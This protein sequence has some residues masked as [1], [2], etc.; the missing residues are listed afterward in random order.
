MAIKQLTVY[1]VLFGDCIDIE[2]DNGEKL[3]VDCGSDN[4]SDSKKDE[5]KDMIADSRP[6]TSEG[7]V[8]LDVVVTHFHSDHYNI[9]SRFSKESIRELYMPDFFS[10]DE[11]KL[12]LYLLLL[13]SIK[14]PNN[15]YSKALAML[16][17]I[18]NLVDFYKDKSK[19][20]LQRRCKINFV[21]KDSIFK[22]FEVLWPDPE[23]EKMKNTIDEVI[24]DIENKINDHQFLLNINIISQ[25][26]DYAER[27]EMLIN[28]IRNVDIQQDGYADSALILNISNEIEFIIDS[29]RR[30]REQIESYLPPNDSIDNLLLFDDTTKK[31]IS[32]IQNLAS[33]VFHNKGDNQRCLFL[34]DITK[35]NYEDYISNRIIS[36][37]YLYIKVS[38]HG[39]KAHFTKL[40]PPRCIAFIISNGKYKRREVSPDYGSCYPKVKIVKTDIPSCRYIKL[41]GTETINDILRQDV[42]Y[43]STYLLSLSKKEAKELDTT[44]GKEYL[45][46][47]YYYT[48][49]YKVTLIKK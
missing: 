38:H 45:G 30:I 49:P 8:S 31:K 40:L 29:I 9:L 44:G 4:L 47:V 2:L 33:L 10:K 39:T 23:N 17:L 37:S 26:N 28:N 7:K 36:N 35:K 41:P 22:E 25:I 19:S 14:S 32:R 5:I 46:V 34:G 15:K 20:I 1:N 11:I 18:P 48:S 13:Y 43:D 27:Y 3:L 42:Y 6:K 24:N 12:E 16:S 21:K